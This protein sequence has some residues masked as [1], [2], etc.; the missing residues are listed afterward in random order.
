VHLHRRA[1]TVAQGSWQDELAGLSIAVARNQTV[2]NILQRVVDLAETVLYDCVGASVTVIE[3]GQPA[4][5]AWT[6]RVA[7]D[8]DRV[9]YRADDGPCL[10]AARTSEVVRFEAGDLR[11][12]A[13]E[14]AA[15]ERGIS[16]SLS[17]PLVVAEV[18]IGALNLYSEVPHGLEAGADELAASLVAEQGAIAIA[19]AHA[20]ATERS[21]AL[22]LQRSLLIDELP[23][24][25]GYEL[26]VR[27]RPASARAQVGGDWYDALV[28]PSGALAVT[29][30][31]VAGHGI[32]AAALMGQLRTGLRAYALEGQDA[33]TCMALLSRLFEARPDSGPQI[34]TACLG[35]VDPVTGMGRL[36]SAGHLPSAV[37]SPDGT[38]HFIGIQGAPLLGV[39]ATGVF[40]DD[41]FALEPGSAL[42]LYTDG[43]IEDRT[44]TLN[45][46]LATLA[47]TLADA[48]GSAEQIC[49]QLITGLLGARSQDD[50][51]ALLVLTRDK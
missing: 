16:H 50:D 40:E 17:V 2:A 28:L 18:T 13:Y 33:A 31:D 24:V 41:F 42:V 21:M 6:Q 47:A 45:D 22:A 48:T 20:F 44:R 19:T 10:Q 1:V 14:A 7:L 9:Q 43:L 12:P 26:A 8:L 11:W 29:V 27:Y 23:N 34:A 5:A 25:A 30:G 51:V 3:Q 35:L 49:D 46:G 37:R 4:T 39:D 38:V 15:R 32:E 36:A